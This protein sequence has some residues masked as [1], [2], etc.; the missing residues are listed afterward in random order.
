MFSILTGT[1]VALY[2]TYGLHLNNYKSD[3]FSVTTLYQFPDIRYPAR[4]RGCS[5]R[6]GTCKE[7]T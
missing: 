7:R 4:N 6:Q 2:F 1:A 5:G 3:K